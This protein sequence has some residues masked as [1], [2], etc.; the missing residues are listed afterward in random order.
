M[1]KKRGAR[2]APRS[3]MGGAPRGLPPQPLDVHTG[4]RH[5]PHTPGGQLDANCT[6]VPS[7]PDG[8]P[9]AVTNQRRYFRSASLRWPRFF[10]ADPLV[11][12]A[13]PFVLLRE[14]P[15]SAPPA[16]LNLPRSLSIVPPLLS[17]ALLRIST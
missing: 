9:L 6:F 17:R 8:G 13:C 16:S 5:R 4:N 3:R 12:R 15:V 11:W 10:R 2:P 14:R 1:K 7:A